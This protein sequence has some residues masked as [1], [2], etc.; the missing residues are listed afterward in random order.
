M[1][2]I[3]VL[4]AFGSRGIS[5][6]TTC[7]QLSQDAVIDAGNIIDGLGEAA[8]AIDHIFVTHCHFDHLLDIPFLIDTFYAKRDKPIRIYGLAETLMDIRKH[9]LNNLIWPDFSHIKLLGKSVDAIEFIEIEIGKTY[10]F[11]SFDIKPIKTEHSVVSCGYVVTKGNSS[12][13]ISADTYLCDDIVSEVNSNQ[14]ISTVILECSFPNSLSRL[15]EV[16]KHL[17]PSTLS[18][19]ILGFSRNVEIYI[20]HLKPNNELE[21]LHDITMYENLKKAVVLYDMM[22]VEF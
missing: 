5:R 10:T 20:N 11:D 21:I 7:I 16:S 1:A 3:K 13:L 15:A 2:K 14:D 4:G 17:T 9:I 22:D 6:N 12:I 19:L 18:K 8:L